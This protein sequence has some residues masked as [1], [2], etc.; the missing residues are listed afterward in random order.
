MEIRSASSACNRLL[1]VVQSRK[2]PWSFDACLCCAECRAGRMPA[3]CSASCT[4]A[5]EESAC[6]AEGGVALVLGLMG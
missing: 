1:Q 4:A 3:Y 6:S 2:G 5:M